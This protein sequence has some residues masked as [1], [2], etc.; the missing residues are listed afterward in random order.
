MAQT[1][2]DYGY[3][4]EPREDGYRPDD[5]PDPGDAYGRAEPAGH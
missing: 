4:G 3:P 2:V 1:R 5:G